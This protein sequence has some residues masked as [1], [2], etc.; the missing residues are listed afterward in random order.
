MISTGPTRPLPAHAHPIAT[1]RAERN[2]ATTPAEPTDP[3][4]VDL[5]CPT[6]HHTMRASRAHLAAAAYTLP[7][8][9]TRHQVHHVSPCYHSGDCLV[10]TGPEYQAHVTAG[11]PA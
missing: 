9:G 7:A 1:A 6:C 10:F 3:Y 8:D 2:D 5:Y 11:R 4:Y